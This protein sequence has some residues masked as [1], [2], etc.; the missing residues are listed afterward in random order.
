MATQPYSEL[1]VALA[2]EEE[3]EKSK[4]IKKNIKEN[5]IKIAEKEAKK[6]S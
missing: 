6:R 2:E 1:S 4:E 5:N 3:N